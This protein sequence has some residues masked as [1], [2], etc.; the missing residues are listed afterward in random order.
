MV[1]RLAEALDADCVYVGEF[2][3]GRVE[4]VKSLASCLDQERE[5][6]FEYPLAGSIA[7]EIA[8]GNPAIYP[9]GVQDLF[10]SDPFLREI[11]AQAFVGI[12][13][14]DSNQQTLGLIAAVYRRAFGNLRFAKSM[15]EIFGPR[16][17]AELERK[18]AEEALRESEQR[19]KAFIA[20]SP[21]AMWRI[22]FEQ[23]IAVALPIEEQIDKIYEYG[24]LAEC[25]DALARFY[26]AETAE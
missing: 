19:H 26:G 5:R 12:P 3:G 21:D 16:A 13:L 4:R 15:L 17:A 22:E 2:V 23:P 14:D 20:R 10:P 1:R 24:Y 9:S 25:H 7:V 8:L 11:G 18:Q 6:R